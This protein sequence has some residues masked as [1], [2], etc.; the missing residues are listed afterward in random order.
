MKNMVP[1]HVWNLAAP[2]GLTPE[3]GEISA[4]PEDDDHQQ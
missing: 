3:A 2:Y 1:A 4:H